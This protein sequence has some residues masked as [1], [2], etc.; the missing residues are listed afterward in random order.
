M[1]RA[2]VRDAEDKSSFEPGVDK[3]YGIAYYGP[4]EVQI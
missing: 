2:R 3:A 4:M 1:H